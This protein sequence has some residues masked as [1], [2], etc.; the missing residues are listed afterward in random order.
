M[1]KCIAAIATPIGT[2]GVSMIRLSGENAHKIA[3]K[4]FLPYEKN[5]EDMKG[6]V[7]AYG[8][9]MDQ[10]QK[11]DDGVALSYRAPNSYTGEDTVE[12]MCHGGK[13]V[14]NEILH[15]LFKAGAL[16]A[17]AGEFTKRAFLNGK[18]SLD[19]AESI[20]DLISADSKE[21]MKMAESGLQGNLTKSI[22]KITEQ[23]LTLSAYFGAW[24]DYPEENI[25]EISS[26]EV[27]RQ[28]VSA[29]KILADLK[30]GY[31]KG[32]IIREG[33]PT[34]LIGKPN[35]GK[36]TLMNYFLKEERSIVSSIPGTTRDVV[37]EKASLG[38]VILNLMDTAGI[39][40]TD[41]EVEKIG[42]SLS[43]DRLEKADIVFALFNGSAVLTEEDFEIAEACQDK[44]VIPIFTKLDLGILEENQKKIREL[45]NKDAVVISVLE[46][47]GL[48][49]LEK[50][51]LELCEL[52]EFS[53]NDPILLTER[54]YVCAD[55][56]DEALERAEQNVRNG[57]EQ[58]LVSIDLQEALNA[59]FEITGERATE[60]IIDEVFSRFCVGK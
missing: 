16:P 32:K 15:L 39:R 21:M 53:L 55:R 56:A 30:K 48:E 29:R 49:D 18:L 28:I 10:N 52:S 1:E 27:L 23:M 26:S 34:V 5:M 50:E 4:V 9:F 51:I 41:D 13:I 7:A 14:T 22:Q 54:Q 19:K 24:F 59:L 6:Y 60:K 25:E 20:M 47:E 45:F 43:K 3:A 42:V 40:D 33:I 31:G 36:S 46:G 44:K 58:D 12:L 57:Y 8:Q 2:G 37:E 38:A 17:S 35:V 11:I